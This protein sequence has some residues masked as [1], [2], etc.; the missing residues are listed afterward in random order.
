MC[1]YNRCWK[2]PPSP[3]QS[4]QRTMVP[5]FVFDAL[6]T[7]NLFW[8]KQRICVRYVW[9]FRPPYSAVLTINVP[10]RAEPCLVHKKQNLSHVKPSFEQKNHVV[11]YIITAQLLAKKKKKIEARQWT[12]AERLSKCWKCPLQRSRSSLFTCF[13]NYTCLIFGLP[14]TRY[15]T[16]IYR[17]FMKLVF[18]L[19]LES[20]TS[21]FS[22]FFRNSPFTFMKQWPIELRPSERQCEMSLHIFS[23]QKKGS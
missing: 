1:N 3:H 15:T 10:T 17:C 2:C 14:L 18:H 21:H 16:C 7:K 22:F 13:S 11:S 20:T 4:P 12:C 5:Q 19:P 8:R 6:S 9:V 23:G